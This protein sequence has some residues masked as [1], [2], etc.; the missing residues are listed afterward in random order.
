[1]ERQREKPSEVPKEVKE[2]AE[3]ELEELRKELARLRSLKKEKEEL[4]K[5]AIERHI[6]N[7][8]DF[9]IA[10]LSYI[11]EEFDKLETILSSQAGEIDNKVYKQ[12]A[13][14]IEAELQELEEE[15][16][17]EKGLIEK[18]L[19]A[20]EKLLSAYPWLEEERKKFMYTMPDKNKQ[21][22]DYTSWKTEWAK[23]LFDYARFA[24]LHIIYIRELNSEKPFSDF[25]KREKYILEIA[26][27]LIS[28]KQAIWLSKKKRKLRVY[29]KTLEVWSD[30]IYK[31]AYDN[32]K[33]EPIMIYE[34]REAKQ[35]DFSNLP[36][37]D[38]EEI[39]KILAKNRRAKVF[40]LENGQLSFKIKL[41]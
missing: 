25:T 26:E 19:T 14:Q 35:E 37:E 38:L 11:E 27:E 24:V 39:F 17:G 1:M 5:E 33:I 3:K 34:I 22:N 15:I 31:W 13:E 8:E 6:I 18:K 30:D 16:I 40:K 23:V 21:N 7:E 2:K 41:E 12:H 28:Q 29:W 36:L 20:Y 32:G 4:E 9:K 10:D